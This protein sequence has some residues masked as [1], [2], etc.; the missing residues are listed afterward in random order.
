MQLSN[1]VYIRGNEPAASA[2]HG[3][4]LEMQ[5]PR[6]HVSHPESETRVGPSSVFQT[7]FLGKWYIVQ[8][9]EPLV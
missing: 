5:I 9:W 7:S 2:P 6:L 8:T 1:M 4:L 3:N